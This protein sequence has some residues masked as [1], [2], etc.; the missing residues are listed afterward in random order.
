MALCAAVQCA[1]VPRQKSERR[2][3]KAQDCPVQQDDKTSQRSTAQNPNGCADVARTGQYTMT[4]RW[5]TRLSGAPIASRIQPI[6]RSG[7]EAINTPTTSFT[8][9]QAF[10]I[11]HSLQEQKPNTPRYNQS[12]QS[13]QIPKINSSA[14]GLVRGSL[15]FFI[16]LV[17]WFGPCGV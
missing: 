10:S 11:L 6:A 12:N 15:V 16:A 9:I 13:T 14:L 8:P 17:V 2:S 5:R 3:Q 4:V 7:W 1:T